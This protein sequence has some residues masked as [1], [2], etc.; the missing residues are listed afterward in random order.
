[1]RLLTTLFV[2]SAFIAK[3]QDSLT[4]EQ[5]I[6]LALE[7]NYD[8]RIAQNDAEI[9]RLNNTRAN[10]GLLPVVNFNAGDNVSAVNFRQKLANGTEIYRPLG[11]FNTFNASLNANWTLYDGRRAYMEKERLDALDMQSRQQLAAQ[12]EA[13][14]TSVALAWF[15]TA[16]RQEIIRNLD[17]V[18]A[19]FRERLKLASNRLEFGF[20]NK[21]DVL[22]AQIDLNDRLKQKTVAENDLA[23]AKQN[24]NSLLNRD[25]QT[26]FSP[27]GLSGVLPVVPDTA[28]LKQQMFSENPSVE[29][30]ESALRVAQ[31]VENQSKTLSKPRI[32]LN[33]G[34]S[35]QRSDNTT[36]FSLFTMQHGP[37]VG[38]NLT[39]PIYT[40]GNLKRQEETAKINTQSAAMRLEQLQQALLLQLYNLTGRLSTLRQSLEVDNQTLGFARENQVIAAERFRLG[41]SNALEIREAQLTLENALFRANQTKFDLWVTDVLLKAL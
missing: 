34:Y 5:T 39:V 41:Q 27:A 24:L 26:M 28:A 4:L 3:A 23:E 36:G 31:L 9:A 11:L 16:R 12:M 30:L 2:L 20:G 1:M 19:T 14:T 21:S 7:R 15:E 18:I 33:G 37:A 32:G 13:T 6:A 22:Q 35:F 25:P 29:S 17:E 40:G 8:V 38:I 10:A